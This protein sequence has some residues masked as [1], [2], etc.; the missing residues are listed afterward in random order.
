[1]LNYLWAIL[2]SI[3]S[4]KASPM[5]TKRVN[6][7]DKTI[8]AVMPSHGAC[9]FALPWANNSPRLGLPE[10]NPNP[11]KSNDV[12]VVILPTKING[13]KVIVATNAFGKIC[14][15]IIF[16]SLWPKALAAFTYSKFLVLKNSALTTPTKLV[17]EKSSNNPSSHQKVGWM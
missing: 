10:G 14:L 6:S 11:K 8:K 9:I 12:K 5:K 16:L 7:K 3:A 15:N 4:L 13:R 2:G 17:Q 1:M